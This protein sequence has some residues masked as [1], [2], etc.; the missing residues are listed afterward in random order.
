[1]E[2]LIDKKERNLYGDKLDY[3]KDILKKFMPNILY[4]ST[5]IFEFSDKMYLEDRG[6]AKDN[7]KHKFYRAVIQDVLDNLNNGL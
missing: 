2:K 6:N 3:A 4:F 1:M 5:T 7:A